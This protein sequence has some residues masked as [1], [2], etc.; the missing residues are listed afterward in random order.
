MR[1]FTFRQ[2]NSG[3]FLDIRPEDGIGSRVCIE[4]KDADAANAKAREI[5]IL[6]GMI[7]SCECCGPRWMEVDDF[8]GYPFPNKYGELLWGSDHRS[9]PSFIHY[10][11]GKVETVEPGDAAPDGW[12]Q[13]YL[14]FIGYQQRKGA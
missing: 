8:D 14:A 6:F 2:N 11:N 10:S 3:G 1:F 5:G 13:I 9:E 12:Q 7:G 4:A